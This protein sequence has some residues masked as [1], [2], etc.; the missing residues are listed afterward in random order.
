MIHGCPESRAESQRTT[1]ST[2]WH[3]HFHDRNGSLRNLRDPGKHAWVDQPHR[4]ASYRGDSDI[5]IVFFRIESRTPAA[6]VD[7]KLFKNP[8]FTR[9]PRFRIFCSRRCRHDDRLTA[10]GATGRKYD[11]AAGRHADPWVCGC[12]YCLHPRRRETV[13][14]V[15]RTQ[16]DDLGLPHHRSVHSVSLAGEHD[17]VGLQNPG[18]HRLYAVWSRRCH[19]MRRPPPMPRFPACPTTQAGSGSGIYKMA[20][21]LG[22][23]FGVAISAAIFT[24]LCGAD[25]TRWLEGVITFQGRQDNVGIREAA[26]IALLFNVVMVAGAIASIMLTVPNGKEKR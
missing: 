2:C 4:A 10:I 26:I 15:W 22:A 8:T 3:H 12:D 25:S 21:S 11:R 5:W 24:A 23:A 7:F 14:A 9:A 17:A 13:A 19:S 16:T 20:S 18:D 1:N 6:F